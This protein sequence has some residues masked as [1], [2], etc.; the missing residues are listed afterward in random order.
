LGRDDA[1]GAGSLCEGHTGLEVEVERDIGLA[2]RG[3]LAVPRREAEVA[4]AMER[5]RVEPVHELVLARLAGVV[6]DRRLERR[7]DPVD[8]LGIERGRRHA[9]HAER[10]HVGDVVLELRAAADDVA[11]VSVDRRFEQRG[12]LEPPHDQQA[13]MTDR[14]VVCQRDILPALRIRLT[15]YSEHAHDDE[16]SRVIHHITS[17]SAV[18]QRKVEYSN[19]IGSQ[20]LTPI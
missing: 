15:G 11:K 8:E 14:D 7:P 16:E 5:H 1:P 19:D 10:E 17:G 4:G 2:E 6:V 18:P 3:E 9:D 20:K 12:D 13:A